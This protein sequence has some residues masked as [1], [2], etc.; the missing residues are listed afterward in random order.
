[1][2]LDGTLE[3]VAALRRSGRYRDAVELLHRARR[4][5]GDGEGAE[6]LSFEEGTLREHDSAGP[7]MC[8]F[9]RGHLARF[10]QGAYAQAVRG[11]M[12]R[13]GCDDP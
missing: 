4:S 7:A 5:L 2:D 9:W 1:M 3:Q 13:A 10:P 11:R 12:G 8:A 6:I